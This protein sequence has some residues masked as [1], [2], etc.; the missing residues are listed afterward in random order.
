M[1]DNLAEMKWSEST[2]LNEMKTA[3]NK[4]VDTF[5]TE[6]NKVSEAVENTLPEE[7]DQLKEDLQSATDNMDQS[8]SK[9]IDEL[10]P[11]NVGLSNVD[12]TSDEDKPV[13]T[14]QQEAI[15]QA[16]SDFAT[17][18]VEEVPGDPIGD[19][20]A[21]SPTAKAYIA[22]RVQ[23]IA[24][25]EG[26]IP[27]TTATTTK[28]GLVKGGGDVIIEENG[29]LKVDQGIKQQIT[30]AGSLAS[31]AQIK[32]DNVAT[33]IG[34]V[35]NLP[36]DCPTLVEAIQ[37]SFT[38]GNE[39]K[40]LLVEGLIA[41]GVE[42]ST[43]DSWETLV[44]LLEDLTA[45]ELDISDSFVESDQVLK[46]V[47]AYGSEGR[48]VGTIPDRSRV[49]L[50][51][52]QADEVSGYL[53]PEITINKATMVQWARFGDAD[54]LRSLLALTA[55]T[56]YYAKGAMVYADPSDVAEAIGLTPDRLTEG[57]KVLGITGTGEGGTHKA[58][59]AS[60]T[61]NKRSDITVPHVDLDDHSCVTIEVTDSGAMVTRLVYLVDELQ[62]APQ[63]VVIADSSRNP[64]A[65]VTV[66]E[67]TIQLNE[68]VAKC[69][70][71]IYGLDGMSI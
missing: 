10:T 63:T 4:A 45:D 34:D 22:E 8:I 42:C 16:I 66:G 29:T 60:D 52:G 35:S 65:M 11:A 56:G 3:H 53:T 13:S 33:S 1:I 32:A 62:N 2:P 55:P 5:A 54:N 49:A 27:V 48:V 20:P 51:G 69:G 25:M 38:L 31:T 28:L 21:L 30:A 59:I 19:D 40:Q 50:N 44:G 57:A 7:I 41:K 71:S 43:S 46:G 18:S 14:L 6:I 12:N 23:E 26:A 70:Y 15:A 61:S 39:K 68:L 58:L 64:L 17:N 24:E 36:E 9:A 67:G 37:Q 47:V